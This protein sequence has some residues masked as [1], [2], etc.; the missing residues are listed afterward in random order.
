M[1]MRV[2]AQKLGF[3]PHGDCDDR[4]ALCIS[5]ATTTWS[6]DDQNV[7]RAEVDVSALE[8]LL[9]PGATGATGPAGPSGSGVTGPTGEVGM[10]GS[11]VS[12]TGPASLA[13]GQ[14]GPAGPTGPAGVASSVT[15]PPGPPGVEG[16]TG[17]SGA[18]SGGT[19]SPGAAG[20]AG[21]TGATGPT[22]ATGSQG[23]TGAAGPTGAPGT[24][25]LTGETGATGPTGPA[26]GLGASG[27]AGAAGPTGATGGTGTAGA[28]GS[29]G[30]TGPP[31]VPGE[32][33]APGV[34]SAL[35]ATPLALGTIYGIG[36]GTAADANVGAGNR[37]LLQYEINPLNPGR[38]N[39]MFGIGANSSGGTGSDKCGIGNQV[40]SPGAAVG[41]VLAD[42]V[43]CVAMNAIRAPGS[44]VVG[45]VAVDTVAIGGFALR[46]G[47]TGSNERNV[48]VGDASMDDLWDVN[49][50]DN[51]AVGAGAM[52]GNNTAPV[53]NRNVSVGSSS[54]AGVVR[55]EL[56]AN[57]GSGSG[58]NTP[59]SAPLQRFSCSLGLGAGE[60]TDDNAAFGAAS[61]IFSG[62]SGVYIGHQS[63]AST[64]PPLARPVNTVGI[65]RN[66]RTL[67]SGSVAVG[68]QLIV[69]TAASPI[70]AINP[71]GTVGDAADNTLRRVV[72]LGFNNSA[73]RTGDH[74]QLGTV[75][76]QV[77]LST[78]DIFC[79][80]FGSFVESCTQ[81]SQIYVYNNLTSLKLSPAYQSSPGAGMNQLLMDGSGDV[82]R[83]SSRADG[84]A[85]VRDLETLDTG[86]LRARAYT[87]EGVQ[88]FGLVAEEVEAA[89]FGLLC[90]YSREG[91]LQGV[92]Y[93]M[94]AVY[95][96]AEL[97]EQ[98]SRL[99]ALEQKLFLRE[100]K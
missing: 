23:P 72:T 69:S 56:L 68:N 59:F 76:R 63:N 6:I 25:G 11:M 31:G 30:P 29:T 99:R 58:G 34:F 41:S 14:D 91:K 57:V 40:Y 61:G 13:A 42:C 94:L 78:Q 83:Q 70:V 22:G 36:N 38:N 4:C 3:F 50:V 49:T 39:V 21:A 8:A 9:P 75:I 81:N 89:G 47:P 43:Q 55:A 44:V 84:K 86:K 45:G 54:S 33:G 18:L 95:L 65:G 24:G 60:I 1:K 51:T 2:K 77:V 71:R 66:V 15:G 93:P 7:I 96:L 46:S 62:G 26:G 92:N 53:M 87:S 52:E 98:D 19:G 32:Q 88:G 90:N 12:P 73:G 17:A 97:R 48:A 16:A 27:A 80:G 74:I 79:L 20:A 82:F 10:S 67:V 5:G 100:R 35:P 28:A 64:A 37:A 85:G